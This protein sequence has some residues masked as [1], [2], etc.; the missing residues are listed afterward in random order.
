MVGLAGF[1][2]RFSSFPNPTEQEYD[3]G[4]VFDRVNDLPLNCHDNLV[5]VEDISFDSL[6]TVRIAMN[7]L[8]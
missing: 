5:K 6:E 8:C 3:H 2:S 1:R 4:G 7:P